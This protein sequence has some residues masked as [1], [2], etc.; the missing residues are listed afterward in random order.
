MKIST[1]E[2]EYLE[3]KTQQVI[4]DEQGTVRDS[5]NSLFPIA[6]GKSIYAE[7]DLLETMTDLF[8]GLQ[9]GAKEMVLP[10]IQLTIEGKEG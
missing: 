10:C 6:V 1:P 4:F 9:V 8:S 2:F 3:Q 5:S 7:I